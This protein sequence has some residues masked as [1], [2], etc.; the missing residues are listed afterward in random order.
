M[1]Q[2]TPSREE[3][4]ALLAEYNKD[5]SHIKHGLA[6]EATM[7]QFA[8]LFGEDEDKWGI[9]GLVHDLDWEMYPEQH[10][11]RT[12]EILTGKG[13]PADYIRAI[14]SHGWGLCTEVKPEHRMEKVLYTIDELTG[15]VISTALVRPSRSL[16]DLTAKSVK[17]KWK[18]KSFAAGVNR[19]VIE[20]G[21]GMLEMELGEVIT[22]TIEGMKRVS[23]DLGL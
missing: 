11:A 20:Q 14:M 7:R 18:E 21:A 17:K 12:N 19:G 15:L 9:I 4:Y 16:S 13:W 23:S 8:R 3:A 6:V 10:C 22:E 2:H 1:E 5:E